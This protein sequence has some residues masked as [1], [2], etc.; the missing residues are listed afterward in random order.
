MSKKIFV[1]TGSPRKGGNS[2]IMADAFI[3]GAEEAGNSVKRFDTAFKNIA[4]CKAC[5]AC[6]TNGRACVFSDDWQEFSD[7]LEAADIVVFAHPIYWSGMPSELKAAIDR[8]Y[9][10]CSAKT[11][12]PLDGKQIVLLLCCECEGM[13]NFSQTLD[14]YEGMSG[15]FK[16]TELGRVLQDSVFE[17]GAVNSHPDTIEKCYQLGKSIQ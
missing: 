13:S 8:T 9:S 11:I 3:R 6:W 7:N 16:W 5:D 2:S 17:K 15:Y 10:Y 12:R 14:C 4:G 1:I